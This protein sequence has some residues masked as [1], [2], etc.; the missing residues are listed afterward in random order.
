MSGTDV[1][2]GTLPG[3]IAGG[4]RGQV[5]KQ[6][7]EPTRE[8]YLLPFICYLSSLAHYFRPRLLL[9]GTCYVLLSFPSRTCYVSY[10]TW[11]PGLH[12]LC[13][14]CPFNVALKTTGTGA[15]GVLIT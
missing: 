13:K 8:Q 15:R 14:K 3:R 9:R 2:R 12:E 10:P 4:N 6:K 5:K 11:I 1:G 7:T